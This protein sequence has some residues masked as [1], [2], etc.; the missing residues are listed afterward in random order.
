VGRMR[1]KSCRREPL[2]VRR[3]GKVK[4]RQGC[5]HKGCAADVKLLREK[6]MRKNK[7]K[8]KRKVT[9]I[10]AVGRGKRHG[11]GGNGWGKKVTE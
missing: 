11:N 3:G 8:K 1:K 9:Q 2:T 7:G 5:W 6:H 10:Y 4:S